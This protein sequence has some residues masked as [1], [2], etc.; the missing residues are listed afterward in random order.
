MVISHV[1][2]IGVM[3][4]PDKIT[5]HVVYNTIGIS[6]FTLLHFWDGL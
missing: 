2:E 1:A 5:A 4:T 6:Q 3:Q